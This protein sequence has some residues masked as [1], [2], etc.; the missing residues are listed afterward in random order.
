MIISATLHSKWK[1]VTDIIR[2]RNCDRYIIANFYIYYPMINK[3]KR[4]I[5]M[6]MCWYLDWVSRYKSAT[7]TNKK[8]AESESFTLQC[9][10][11]I[12]WLFEYVILWLFDLSSD[13]SAV[14]QKYG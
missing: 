7:K 9:S 11:E 14:G 13:L 1:F 4:N 10:T 2:I 8:S 12:F 6:L 5:Y 3:I